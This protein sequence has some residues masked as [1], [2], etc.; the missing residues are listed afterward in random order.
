MFDKTDK[1][2]KSL[3]EAMNFLRIGRNRNYDNLPKVPKIKSTLSG[4]TL[5][6]EFS[7]I[8]LQQ[9]P[10]KKEKDYHE[11]A[12]NYVK[13]LAPHDYKNFLNKLSNAPEDVKNHY[14]TIA[15]LAG[16]YNIDDNMALDLWH[17]ATRNRG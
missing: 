8:D 14:G 11:I 1:V 4:G 12:A 3:T 7:K 10:E 13:S 6:P 9:A 17:T 2:L 15:T 5:T 16:K